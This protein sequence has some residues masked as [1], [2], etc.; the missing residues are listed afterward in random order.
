MFKPRKKLVI[1]KVR[2]Q[3]EDP[4]E[5]LQKVRVNCEEEQDIKIR[6][7]L[8]SYCN[9]LNESLDH[10]KSLDK[11][12]E[13]SRKLYRLLKICNGSKEILLYIKTL[14]RIA[15]SNI[16]RLDGKQKEILQIEKEDSRLSS[17][18]PKRSLKRSEKDFEFDIMMLCE[19][20][21]KKKISKKEMKSYLKK[22]FKET[23]TKLT[24]RDS[25]EKFELC[26]QNEKEIA[27]DIPRSMTPVNVLNEKPYDADEIIKIKRAHTPV[28]RDNDSLS[29]SRM[30]TRN[31]NAWSRIHKEFKTRQSSRNSS[32]R[33]N[34]SLSN[35]SLGDLKKF[36]FTKT[37]KGKILMKPTAPTSLGSPKVLRPSDSFNHWTSSITKESMD[38]LPLQRLNKIN[39]K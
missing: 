19:N 16:H 23:K 7:L 17:K 30:S 9:F 27:L 39:K 21:S 14:I 29:D 1:K 5:S 15:E 38:R 28:E 26:S 24:Q 34:R 31:Q 35:I 37:K 18:S 22:L 11:L 8:L 6:K 3:Q 4:S 20:Y 36:N 33:S 10:H 12:F 32:S 25:H 2:W 13:V